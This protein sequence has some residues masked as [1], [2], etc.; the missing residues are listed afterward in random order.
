MSIYSKPF[1][2]GKHSFSKHWSFRWH[3]EQSWKVL[4]WFVL[5]LIPMGCVSFRH[6]PFMKGSAV[7]QVSLI[8]S[9]ETSS[10]R[11]KPGEKL[12]LKK[13]LSFALRHN[14]DLAI[15]QQ[16]VRESKARTAVAQ[17]GHWPKLGASIA[18]THYLDPQ[19]LLPFR[20]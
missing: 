9:R 2:K 11:L 7:P 4:S 18:Y 20:V 1:E 14:P 6:L 3:R 15:Q 16:N 19:R 10:L 12:T 8:H 5:F 17:T 13:A